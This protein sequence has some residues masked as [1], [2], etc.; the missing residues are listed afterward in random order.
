MWKRRK[1][2]DDIFIYLQEGKKEQ[3]VGWGYKPSMTASLGKLL[4]LK[5]PEPSQT[6]PLSGVQ[7]S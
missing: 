1:L 6:L 4:P 5:V 7:E 3:L 2:A